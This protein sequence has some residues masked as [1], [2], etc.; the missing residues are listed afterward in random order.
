MTLLS[1]I[2]SCSFGDIALGH[3]DTEMAGKRE[4]ALYITIGSV[5]KLQNQTTHQLYCNLS[6]TLVFRSWQ[7]AYMAVE[8][9]GI[10]KGWQCHLLLHT[11]LE[12]PPAGLKLHSLASKILNY[13]FMYNSG[14]PLGRN[15]RM[16]SGWLSTVH[17]T[18]E[19]AEMYVG[20]LVL[21]RPVALI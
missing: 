8:E 17:Q 6:V 3:G 14:I 5:N 4:S 2:P 20:H 7:G 9:I 19:Y 11:D 21:N 13:L 16:A 12:A 15:M 10:S 18:D 1:R